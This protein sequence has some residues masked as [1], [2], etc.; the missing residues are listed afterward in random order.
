[1]NEL[2]GSPNLNQGKKNEWLILAIIIVAL[3]PVTI[4]ATILHVAIPTLTLSIGATGNEVLW[5]IDTYP[6]IMAGLLLPMGVLGDK[7]GHKKILL[8]GVSIFALASLC[9]GLST[10]PIYLILSRALLALGGS[11]IMPVT[12]A[13]IRQTFT[14][15]KKCGQALGIWAAVGTMGAALGPLIGGILVEHYSWEAVFLV[16]IP[17]LLIMIPAIWFGIPI[18][19]SDPKKSWN[20][21]DAVLLLIGVITFVYALKSVFKQ[22]QSLWISLIAGV[23]GSIFLTWFFKKQRDT[24]NPMIDI[25][26]LKDRRILLGMLL[27]FV[28]M[29]V[30]VGFEFLLAQELQFVHQFSPITA[31]QFMLPF[32]IAAAIAGPVTGSVMNKFSYRKLIIGVLALSSLSFFMLSSLDFS[33]MSIAL[34]CWLVVLG[35]GLGMILMAA[36]SSIMA[37]VPVDKAGAAGSME[38]IAYELGTGLGIAFFGIV[39]SQIFRNEIASTQVFS[40]QLTNDAPASISDALI[41]ANSLGGA[42]AAEIRTAAMDAFL[43]AHHWVLITAGTVLGALA[44]AMGFLLPKKTT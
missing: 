4:D 18:G 11:M 37:A 3:I 12:L 42:K 17:L 24:S 25:G 31:G 20:F 26:L 10:L 28:P 38:S 39:L 15:E 23:I 36:T 44:V 5:I 21:K 16:N 43:V 22:H 14:E 40:T 6:L 35:F 34:F 27:C 41:L 29:A 1:M 7:I 8:F 32:A 19:V 13:I 30:I 9:A 33:I 2:T